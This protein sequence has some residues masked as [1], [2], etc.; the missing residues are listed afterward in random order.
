M[1][2]PF[3]PGAAA[4]GDTWPAADVRLSAQA[5]QWSGIGAGYGRLQQRGLTVTA[6]GRGWAAR[7]RSSPLWLPIAGGVGE[8]EPVAPVLDLTARTG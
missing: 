6:E 3:Q 2:V 7:S 5:G 8:Y 1:L 4:T